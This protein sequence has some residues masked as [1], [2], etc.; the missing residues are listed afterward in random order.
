[1]QR[2][3]KSPIKVEKNGVFAPIHRVH[4]CN[5]YT[6]YVISYRD[7]EANRQRA[8]LTCIVL[9]GQVCLIK[10]DDGSDN[11]SD[12]DADRAHMGT[13]REWLRA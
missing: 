2:K 9:R 11:S 8:G 4:S 5:G 10:A 7:Y 3:K 13:E 6:S 12:G 1:M